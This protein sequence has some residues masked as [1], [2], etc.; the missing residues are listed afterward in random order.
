M[1]SHITKGT[2]HVTKLWTLKWWRFSWICPG[3]TDI[4]TE[5]FKIKR[6]RDRDRDV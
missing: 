2:V 4:L 1:Y 6:E 3:S 5:I